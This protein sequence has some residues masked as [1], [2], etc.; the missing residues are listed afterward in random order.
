MRPP[1]KRSCAP[2]RSSGNAARP[3]NA[4]DSCC[5]P[6][7]FPSPALCFRPSRKIFARRYR[8]LLRVVCASGSILVQPEKAGGAYTLTVPSGGREKAL[9]RFGHTGEEVSLRL[10][11]ANLEQDCCYGAFLRGAFLACGTMSNP[12]RDYHLEFTVP[13]RR[14]AEDLSVLLRELWRLPL[15]TVRTS[16][17]LRSYVVRKAST[18][19]ICSP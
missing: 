6:S 1:S 14:L 7:S 2:S 8:D 5:F 16:G 12:E 11:R 15:K 17:A 4:T 19:R 3:P 10:N 18:S 9:E 13:R